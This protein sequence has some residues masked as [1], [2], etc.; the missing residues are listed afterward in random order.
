MP[1]DRWSRISEKA[2][3]FALSL[4][5]DVRCV[6]IQSGEE[7]DKISTDWQTS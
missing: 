7:V 4:S 3:A 6:H 2:L 5:D 1:I